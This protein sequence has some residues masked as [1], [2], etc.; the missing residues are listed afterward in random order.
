MNPRLKNTIKYLLFVGLGGL[1]LWLA[2]RSADPQKLL[3]DLKHAHYGWVFLSMVLGW[4]AVISRGY[5]W[6][7][8]LEPLG[9]KVNPWNASHAVAVGYMANLAVP[10][11]GELARCTSLNQV[12]KVPVNQLFGTVILERAVDLVMMI[13][14]ITLAVIFQWQN[15]LSLVEIT[16]SSNGHEGAS[17]GGSQMI[18]YILFGALLFFVLVFILFRNRIIYHPRFAVVRNFWLG[19]KEG[20][21]TIF[22]MKRTGMFFFHTLFIWTMYFMMVYVVFYAIPATSGLTVRECFLIQVAGSLGIVL[23][24]PGGIGAYHFLVMS[25]LTV[26]GLTKEEGLSFATIVHSSQTLMLLITGLVGL[27]FL[28]FERRKIKPNEPSGDPPKQDTAKGS[29]G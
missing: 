21:K 11:A 19:M 10:R 6:V 5:R 28:Y 13:I 24:V 15:L 26:L 29:A 22:R 9:Y 7:I 4:L 18:L 17:G 12:E 16:S 8:L 25:A 27:I 1:L 2:F 3:D 14:M 23:P 20:F